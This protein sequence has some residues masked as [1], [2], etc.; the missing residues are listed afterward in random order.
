M[1]VYYFNINCGKII[2][3]LFCTYS[4]VILFLKEEGYFHSPGFEPKC[5]LHAL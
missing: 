3:I 2:Y 5:C 4:V 1:G